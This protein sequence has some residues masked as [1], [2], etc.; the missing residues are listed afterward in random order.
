M[1]NTILFQFSNLFSSLMIEYPEIQH[2][3]HIQSTVTKIKD[4]IRKRTEPVEEKK[5]EVKPVSSIGV[6]RETDNDG[7]EIITL[8]EALAMNV[9]PTLEPFD[10]ETIEDSKAEE[11]PIEETYKDKVKIEDIADI[12]VPVIEPAKIVEEVNIETTKETPKEV[13]MLSQEEYNAKMIEMGFD[14]ETVVYTVLNGTDGYLDGIP[15]VKYNSDSL[16]KNSFD[17]ETHVNQDGQT[18]TSTE[19]V[20]RLDSTV[21]K[22]NMG[23]TSIE[24]SEIDAVV[25]KL[26]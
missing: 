5:E 16:G 7:L 2:V 20:T 3:M 21:K 1:M 14:P 18:F 22:Y 19:K 12:L 23:G 13:S 4:S 15:T 17:L 24:M 10:D 9:N 25:R 8:E 26:V 11:V 6:I